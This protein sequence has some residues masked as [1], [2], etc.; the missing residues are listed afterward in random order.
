MHNEFQADR[1]STETIKMS[2]LDR[3]KYAA[4]GIGVFVIPSA[5]TVGAI[6]ASTRNAKMGLEAARLNLEAAKLNKLP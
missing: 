4:V 5:I 3:V 2:K 6:Y 1:E